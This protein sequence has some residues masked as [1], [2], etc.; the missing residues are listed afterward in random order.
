M[1]KDVQKRDNH[2]VDKYTINTCGIFKQ[3]RILADLF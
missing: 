2:Q 1:R 3:V